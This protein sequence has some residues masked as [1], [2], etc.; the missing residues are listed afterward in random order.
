MKEILMNIAIAAI[1]SGLFKLL[2]PENGMKKQINL[3]IA[4][5]F[6]SS[7]VFFITNG[8]VTFIADAKSL[9]DQGGYVDF[10]AQYTLETQK[11]IAQELGEQVTLS[12]EDQGIRVKEIRVNVH[13]SDNNSISINEILL[14]LYQ[15]DGLDIETVRDLV[16]EKVGDEILVT[17]E[18]G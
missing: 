1:L 3:L 8:D 9:S 13:I 15:S 17:V 14:V 16:R 2:L 10:T 5:F 6:L 7:V 11:A 12:L 4:C 18:Q